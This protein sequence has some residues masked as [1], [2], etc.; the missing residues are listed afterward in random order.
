MVADDV[1]LRILL[2]A[3]VFRMETLDGELLDLPKPEAMKGKATRWHAMS[4][5]VPVPKAFQSRHEKGCR[6]SW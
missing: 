5:M 4:P 6:P 1:V 3:A 2:V